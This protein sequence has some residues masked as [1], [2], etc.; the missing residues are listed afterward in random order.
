MIMAIPPK[1]SPEPLYF[2]SRIQSWARLL[3]RRDTPWKVKA[4]LGVAI[5][6][7]LSP[8]DLVPDWIIGFGMLDDLAV[9]S[10]L[11]AW[12][13]KIADTNKKQNTNNK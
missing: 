1:D 4:I 13:L 2:W 5:I 12:A 10:F 3:F 11:V 7:L 9:V 8:F 6:Y